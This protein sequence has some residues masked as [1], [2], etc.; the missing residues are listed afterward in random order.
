M[1]LPIKGSCDGSCLVIKIGDRWPL[2]NGGR[3]EA[4]PKYKNR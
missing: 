1:N 2:K 4:S 3:W